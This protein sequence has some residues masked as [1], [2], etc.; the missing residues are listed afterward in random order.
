[1]EVCIMKK[2]RHYVIVAVILSMVLQTGI[3]GK[4]Y[5]LADVNG[6]GVITGEDAA[7]T[8][9]KVLNRSYILPME[10]LGNG[11]VRY[12]D[13]DGD[14]VLS[15]NDCALIMQKT[16][17]GSFVLPI[18]STTGSEVTNEPVTEQ[19]STAI[20]ETESESTTEST[21]QTTT[22]N[23]TEITTEIVTETITQI[24]TQDTTEATT[25]IIIED[26][27]ETT[28]ET[29]T[30]TIT[31]T[32]AES[33]TE[34]TTEVI[35]EGT[36][37]NLSDKERFE[38]IDILI[39]QMMENNPPNAPTWNTEKMGVANW[40]YINGCM[41]K[42]FDDLYELTGDK[43][44]MEFNNTFMEYYIEE[45]GSIPLYKQS[46]YNLD[47]INSGKALFTLYK[48]TINPKY[49]SAIERLQSQLEKQPR[50]SLG[51]FYHKKIYNKQVW[52]DGLYMALPFYAEYETTYNNNGN[53]EDIY[54]QFENVHNI[55]RDSKTGLYYHGYDEAKVQDWAD[56]TTGLSKSFWLR[57]M[58]W[59]AM[60][61]VDTIELMP[62]DTQEH[63]DYK[64]R[65]IDNF[66]EYMEAVRS[67]QDEDTGMWYQVVDMGE[68]TGN[69][70]E[71]SGSGGMAYAMMKGA[72]LGYLDK[73]YYDSGKKAFDGICDIKLSR[74]GDGV[75]LKDICIV[76]GLGGTS[77]YATSHPNRDGTYEYYI[78][79]KIGTN[80]AKGI[81]PLLYAYCEVQKHK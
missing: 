28:T 18:E 65:M 45:D 24:T 58:A 75:V 71:T 61:S 78:A 31:Q 37:E 69:Y 55:M 47:N 8:L 1:M 19:S 46:D 74:T 60:A 29:V 23:A 77:K 26:T 6:D 48:Y 56:K 76:A 15:A 10:K 54:N 49:L 63:I 62:A 40:N 64:K 9:Q 42:A 51:N 80:D 36:T 25:K 59:Y 50:I 20:A 67:Y 12:G 14:G 79:E 68:R 73:S 27:T 70:L 5:S 21:I 22:E 39:E 4:E 53:I 66:A 72:R 38:K 33:T 35:T 52:L 41:L 7:M 32:T 44:Y 30:E 43:K 34:A 57:S 16:L 17:N 81:A 13:V 3:Q 11:S 2:V